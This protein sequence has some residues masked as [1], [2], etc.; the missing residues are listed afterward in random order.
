LPVLFLVDGICLFSLYITFINFAISPYNLYCQALHT[1][2]KAQGSH[3]SKKIKF[4]HPVMMPQFFS[5]LFSNEGGSGRW[6]TAPCSE[7]G[8]WKQDSLSSSI[9]PHLV[10]LDQGNEKDIK[11]WG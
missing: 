2:D 4:G 7:A 5:A 9:S 1:Y 6:H 3:S 10:S 8:R 11:S